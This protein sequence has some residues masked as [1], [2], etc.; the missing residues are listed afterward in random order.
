MTFKLIGRFETSSKLNGWQFHQIVL[1]LRIHNN[2]NTK[3]ANKSQFIYFW[4]KNYNL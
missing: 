1:K 2:F 4:M 3:G